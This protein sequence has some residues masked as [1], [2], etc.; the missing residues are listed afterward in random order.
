MQSKRTRT[1]T[2]VLIVDD[3]AA[4]LRVTA[5]V[6]RSLGFQVLTAEDGA[7][8]LRVLAERDPEVHVVLTDLNMPDLDG[9]SLVDTLRIAGDDV[10]V[11]VTTGSDVVDEDLASRVSAVLYKPHSS[12]QLADALAR[13]LTPQCID[14]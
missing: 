12:V 3:D 9:R 11:V 14:A 13:A 8:A 7:A 10:P 6:V 2:T 5:L 4:V 1:C